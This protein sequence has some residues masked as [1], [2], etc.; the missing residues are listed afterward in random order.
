MAPPCPL[1][2]K[3][4]SVFTKPLDIVPSAPFTIGI[5]VTFMFYSFFSS[6][7]IIIIII[8]IICLFIYLLTMIF[9]F[10]VF[11]YHTSFECKLGYETR[12][13]VRKKPG[14]KLTAGSLFIKR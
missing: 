8:I 4:S 10:S 9:I 1:I 3:S 5:T 12:Y 14:Y 6:I 2:S 7:I 11:L 13:M